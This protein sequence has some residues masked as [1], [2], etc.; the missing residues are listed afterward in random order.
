MILC[1]E[2]QSFVLLW[3]NF[4]LLRLLCNS[5]FYIASFLQNHN[6]SKQQCNKLSLYKNTFRIILCILSENFKTIFSWPCPGIK[7]YHLKQH[8]EV[9]IPAVNLARARRQQ[10]QASAAAKPTFYTH[11]SY[12]KSGRKETL[13]SLTAASSFPYAFL[14]FSL[15]RSLS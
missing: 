10:Q 12:R 4:F 11:L 14:F 6:K 2:F 9:A 1:S 5:F 7:F 8:F 15:A 13:E 3:N